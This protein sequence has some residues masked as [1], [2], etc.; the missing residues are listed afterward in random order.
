MVPPEFEVPGLNQQVA[1]IW[2]HGNFSLLP[3]T[4]VDLTGVARAAGDLEYVRKLPRGITVVSVVATV[5]GVGGSGDTLDVGTKQKGDGNWTDDGDYFIDGQSIA[6]AVS[7]ESRSNTQHA[8]LY[9]DEENV[10]LTAT[11]PA[12]IGAAENVV[13]DFYVHYVNTGNH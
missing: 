12:A 9:I 5:R 8:P 10:Y 2:A 11:Y 1:H 13:V 6:A 7:T 4:T 3:V